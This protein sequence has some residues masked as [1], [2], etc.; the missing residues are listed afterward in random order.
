MDIQPPFVWQQ[1]RSEQSARAT[2]TKNGLLKWTQQV[3]HKAV[4]NKITP[5]QEVSR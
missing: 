3:K 1:L 4:Q 5:K 2:P